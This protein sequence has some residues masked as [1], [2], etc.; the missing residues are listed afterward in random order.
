MN[1]EAHEEHEAQK[2]DFLFVFFVLLYLIIFASCAS[3][4]DVGISFGFRD[5]GFGCGAAALR[6][7][8]LIN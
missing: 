2:T 1:H 4:A 8:W 7:S 5:F 6:P 3:L